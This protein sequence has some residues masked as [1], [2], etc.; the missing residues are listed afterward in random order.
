MLRSMLP[1]FDYNKDE[2]E[3]NEPGVTKERRQLAT[4]EDGSQYEGEWNVDTNLRHG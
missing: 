2:S 4:L 3:N 1:P